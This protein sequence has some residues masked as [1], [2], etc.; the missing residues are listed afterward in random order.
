[1]SGEAKW[2]S[3]QAIGE[4]ALREDAERCRK[5]RAGE[6]DRMVA[7]IRAVRAYAEAT[8]ELRDIA[9]FGDVDTPEDRDT[10][11]NYRNAHHQAARGLLHVLDLGAQLK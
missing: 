4:R 9:D 2:N 5:C 8:L 1:M 11:E 6:Y 3:D 10:S 7:T